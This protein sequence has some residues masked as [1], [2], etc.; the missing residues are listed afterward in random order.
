MGTSTNYANLAGLMP[1]TS[2]SGLDSLGLSSSYFPM[3]SGF[4]T[5]DLLK[6]FGNYDPLNIYS[7]SL[8]TSSNIHS[9]SST[10]PLMQQSVLRNSHNPISALGNMTVAA[11][12]SYNANNI[13]P[14]PISVFAQP[15]SN[16]NNQSLVPTMMPYPAQ[17]SGS[18]INKNLPKKK[19][20]D[21]LGYNKKDPN[22][23]GPIGKNLI[24]W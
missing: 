4:Y 17:I 10:S 12:S 18:Q 14:A 8:P 24:S 9:T 7:S 20:T 2:L 11:T 1:S 22:K 5:H 6:R 13:P 15:V 23:N 16:S 19:V 3:S 21:L